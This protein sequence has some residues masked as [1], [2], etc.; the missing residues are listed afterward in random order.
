MKKTS[1]LVL[2]FTL[3]SIGV[4]TGSIR[5]ATAQET[6]SIKPDGSVEPAS[7]PISS[8]DN[9]TYTL[10]SNIY[11]SLIV[12]RSNVIIEGAGYTIEGNGSGNGINLLNVNCVTIKRINVKGFY[13]GIY[14]ESV[15]YS[16]I[17]RNN[18]TANSYDG[19]RLTKSTRNVISLNDVTGNNQDGIKLSSS[20]SN[21]VSE[22]NIANNN[23]DGIQLYYSSHNTVYGNNITSSGKAGVHINFSEE[24]NVYENNIA[25]NVRYGVFMNEGANENCA[26]GNNISENKQGIHS[27]HSK[28]N[29]I[30]ENNFNSNDVQAFSY[31]IWNI[32]QWDNGTTGNYWS[33]Y[34]GTD[35]SGDGIGDTQYDIRHENMTTEPTEWDRYP[36][37]KPITL[38]SPIWQDN[39]PPT[40]FLT[41]PK[42]TT[43]T[44]KNIP[45]TFMPDE[46]I[47]WIGYSLDKGNNV[48]IGGN[49]SL[50]SLPNG[51]H[52]VTVYANDAV[53]N[54]GHST[55]DFTINTLSPTE[56]GREIIDIDALTALLVFA[57]LAACVTVLGFLIRRRR[58]RKKL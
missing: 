20:H 17:W 5:S 27:Y 32:S 55:V 8:V 43:Y 39:S 37:M 7:A 9:I 54:I 1:L 46:P 12:N 22:N 35:F 13:H 4:P 11:S 52:T 28:S 40:L 29:T 51:A 16:L 42:N 57:F 25:H 38:N 34:N 10:S 26:R 47:T 36:L 30:F 24:N 49:T 21:T 3:L 15:R 6:I 48:T 44:T 14:L 45:L 33:D 50:V 58:L 56:N 31:I 2:A 18:L 19:I 53:G 41:S 23:D